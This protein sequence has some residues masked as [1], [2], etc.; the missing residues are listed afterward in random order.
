MTVWRYYELSWSLSCTFKNLR[1]RLPVMLDYMSS[2]GC[3]RILKISPHEEA[4]SY[5]EVRITR[6][7]GFGPL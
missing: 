5:V 4:N 6:E 7:G 2:N 3:E 1:S